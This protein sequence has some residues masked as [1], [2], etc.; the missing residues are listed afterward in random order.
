MDRSTQ[1]NLTRKWRSQNFEEIVGQD[2]VVRVLK[3]S[4]YK[5][6]FFPVY[7][8][9]GQRGCG[10]TSTA[11]IFAAAL[12]C[13]SLP[14]FQKDP[15][16]N[17]LPCGA[18]QSCAA[19]MQQQHPDFIE[20]DAASYTGVDNIRNIIETSSFLPVLGSKKI[21]LIDEVHM[22]SKAA[23][24]ALLKIL[25]EPPA[26]V[27]FILATTEIA[28]IIDTVQ[29]RAFRVFFQPVSQE[30]SVGH[31]RSICDKEQIVYDQDA[32]QVI[33]QESEGSVRD[34]L[35]LL[36]RARFA[37]AKIT[38][39]AVVSLLGHV[40]QSVLYKLCGAVLRK[41]IHALIE[42]LTEIGQ[43]HYSASSVWNQVSELWYDL[44]LIKY[45]VEPKYYFDISDELQ[46][47]LDD[48]SIDQL[49]AMFEYISQAEQTMNRVSKKQIFLE[50]SLLRLCSLGQSAQF[51][52]IS[53]TTTQGV[54]VKKKNIVDQWNYILEELKSVLDPMVYSVFQEAEIS[55]SGGV[56]QIRAA[57]N[58]VFFEDLV[59]EQRSVWM[60]ILKK[61]V[62]AKEVA[63]VFNIIKVAE[64]R[65]ALKKALAVAEP[66]SY[67]FSKYKKLSSEEIKDLKI[68]SA[69][70]SHFDGDVYNITGES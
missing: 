70:L 57:E 67:S 47:L 65:A 26:S 19:M 15:Q 30:V 53:Q 9:A 69:V 45:G 11:R 59:N 40:D 51:G 28:K 33:A 58:L 66:Q 64:K 29:S 43:Q 46:N 23:F 27:L 38:R 25:E 48:V 34:A 6:H 7:L 1:L 39:K 2:L 14:K 61:Y 63:I 32:L 54:E 44:I 37:Y 8:F 20:I 21:Y 56:I 10:K 17:P 68:T 55:E 42:Q 49:L 18:C 36:E 35:N 13:E 24:N 3:N 62:D 60:S 41:D 4:L 16:N 31:L 52:D 22:L 5:N 12:N 50:M